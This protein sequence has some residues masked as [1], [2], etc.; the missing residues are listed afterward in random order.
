ML[1]RRNLLSWLPLGGMARPAS[2]TSLPVR[3]YRYWKRRYPRDGQFVT[4]WDR[5]GRG[6]EL[7]G[8]MGRHPVWAKR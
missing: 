2:L 7:K 1:T 8:A 5:P 3:G 4:G 6:W